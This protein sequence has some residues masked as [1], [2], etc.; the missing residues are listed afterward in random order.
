MSGASSGE[1][2]ENP[3][4]KKE[5]D[6]RNKGQVARSNEVV[7]TVS[8]MSV[9]A[10]IWINFNGLFEKLVNVMDESIR[11]AHGVEGP[12]MLDGLQAAKDATV[13]LLIPVLGVTILAGIAGNYLQIGSL[14]AVEGVMP[15]LE[16]VSPIAGFKRI[17]S[18]KQLVEVL[19]SIIKIV[20]LSVLLYIVIRAALS[21]LINSVYCGMPCIAGMTSMVIASLLGFTAFAFIVVAVAD[22]WYQQHAHKKSLMMSKDEVKREYKESEGD[23]MIK[24]QRKQ[25]AQEL[26]MGDPPAKAKKSSAVVMNPV[27]LAV[28]IYYVPDETPLPVVTAKGRERVA[29][30]MRAAAEEAGVPVFHHIP[31]ARALYA[32]A[33]VNDYVPDSMF[34]TL[35]EVLVWIERNRENLYDGPLQH[36]MID[37]N[38][39]RPDKQTSGMTNA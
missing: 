20:F 22:F 8:L 37:L 18:M 11:A 5:R 10:Y 21:P 13:D 26:V 28:A 15:K 17:F 33:P 24:G 6:A 39:D 29:H 27:H 31:L 14:F 19:K 3:T 23:P 35:A 4:P 25:F 34:E 7:A 36:G 9:I 2:T 1:K 16:K 12:R 32:D 38:P 30:A